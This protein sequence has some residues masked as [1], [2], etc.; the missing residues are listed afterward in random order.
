MELK[1]RILHDA[2]H[3]VLN[4]LSKEVWSGFRAMSCD[5]EWNS[6]PITASYC[7]HFP[8]SKDMSG[9]KHEGTA[10]PCVL[11]CDVS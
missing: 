8:E 9:V 11:A 7:C 1:L 5:K 6:H 10:R 2:M 3:R 4:P